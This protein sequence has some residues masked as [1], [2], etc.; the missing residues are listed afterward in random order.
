MTFLFQYDRGNIGSLLVFMLIHI[1]KLNPKRWGGGLILPGGQEIARHFSQ[2]HTMVTKFLYFIKK[3]LKYKVVKSFLYYL[4]R[5]S[6]NS[7]ETEQRS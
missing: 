6:R 3:H 7:A 4:D 1:T 2:D 5:Y